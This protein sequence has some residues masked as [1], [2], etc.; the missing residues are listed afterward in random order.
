M[1]KPN[2]ELTDEENPELRSVDFARALPV[3][4]IQIWPL[5]QR[6]ASDYF[7]KEAPRSRHQLLGNLWLARQ[8]LKDWMVAEGIRMAK[9]VGRMA[10]QESKHFG[11]HMETNLGA[12]SAATP[13]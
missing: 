11:E 9:S 13:N 5:S 6:I 3:R 7:K 12:K 10:T 4:F 2:P 8:R 1:K